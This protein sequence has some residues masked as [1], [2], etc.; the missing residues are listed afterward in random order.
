MRDRGRFAIAFLVLLGLPAAL[1]ACGWGGPYEVYEVTFFSPEVITDPLCT[2]F[3]ATP[4]RRF[5]GVS[6]EANLADLSEANL[7]EWD[8]F[9]GGKLPRRVW[10]ELLYRAPLDR[11]DN[12]I[13]RLKGR[14]QAAQ[15][16]EDEPFVAFPERDVLIAALYYVGFAKRVEPYATERADHW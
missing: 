2:P 16:A 9:W 1:L 13:F 6:A 12:L 4:F 8:A 10:A 11:L 7:D 14:P 15:V 5:Y 3:L